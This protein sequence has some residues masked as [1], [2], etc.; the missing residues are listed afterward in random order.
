M[1]ETRLTE[2]GQ[3]YMKATAAEWGWD[4]YWGKP[5][6]SPTGGIWG[7]PQG[8]VGLLFKKGWNVRKVEPDEDDPITCRLWHSGRWLHTSAGIGAGQCVLNVC[9]AYGV[10]GNESLN[11]E[12]WELVICYLSRLGNA[13]CILLTDANFNFD[14]LHKIPSA[15][16]TA[17][18]DGWLV[19]ADRAHA[20]LHG[21]PCVC[22]F[23]KDGKSA[24]R[25]DGLLVTPAQ[26]GT[27]ADVSALHDHSLPGH[28]PVCFTFSL[29]APLQKVIKMRKLP[30]FLPPPRSEEDAQK[31]SETLLRPHQDEWEQLLLGGDVNAIWAQWTWLAEEVGMAL[32]CTHLTIDTPAPELP[33]APKATPRGRGT[34]R[35]LQETTLAPRSIA[36]TGGPRTR[37]LSKITGTLGALR[38]VI[39]WQRSQAGIK[40]K[41]V[42]ASARRKA[43]Q[44]FRPGAIP[45]QVELSW[46]AACR[47]MRKVGSAFRE[48]LLL[49]EF[50]ALAPDP[51]LP[52]DRPLPAL[53]DT[54]HTYDQLCLLGK[55]Y[56]RHEERARLEKWKAKMDSAW[57]DKPKEVYKWIQNEYQPP[58]VMLLDPD[59][60]QP[61]SNIQRMDEILHASWDKV[62]RKYADTPEPDVRAFA[63]KY[64]RFLEKGAR[65]QANPITGARL[66]KCLRKMGVHTAT[67]LDGW[68][69]A[70]LLPLP[71]R[72]LDMLS[73][74]LHLI[75]QTGCWPI[76]LAR[77]YVSLIPK[78][79][80]MLPMQQRPLSVLSQIYRVWAGIRL[81]KCM[82]WQEHWI[83]P[84]AY[85]FRKKRGATDA[86]SHI[87][88]LLELHKLIKKVLH[89]FGLDYVK[90]FDLIP[91]SIVLYIAL[92][93]GM[94]P[95][96][97]KALSGMYHTLTRCF[98]IMGCCASF[99]AATNG[100][101][102]GCPLS[103]ILINLMT[104]VWKRVLDAQQQGITVSVQRLPPSDQPVQVMH[105]VLTAL[106][107]ADDTYGFAAGSNTLTPLL[108]C[109][110]TWL[111]DT[112]QGVNAKKS[113]GFSSDKQHPV[114]AALQGVPFPISTEFKSLGAGVRTT[115][116]TCSG[117]LILKRIARACS[118]L[119]RVHGAQGN[120]ERRCDVISTMITATG[121]HAAEIVPL[122]PR[123]LLPFESKVMRTI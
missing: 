112:G 2:A 49:H 24:N 116:A 66:A 71:V 59:T 118:L 33:F 43:R 100:I 80:G 1:E 44:I 98:K 58:L 32:S 104:S 3:R 17:M 65:M 4:C 57:M 88:M 64:D 107:Y 7:A 78:G 10:A 41:K 90:C 113:V 25:I 34:E 38:T 94:D 11:R 122:R 15:P 5:L 20:I 21:K 75:E 52:S 35:M 82:Q 60:N 22:G 81:E 73:Q 121:L 46:K 39:Q 92:A 63:L 8:G 37:L 26:A 70:D 89:G 54:M 83:H 74:L 19:D 120:F 47:R 23:S 115:D 91:Q 123:D 79:E 119:G 103:V 40:G 87:S 31:I 72:P 18:A 27:L 55:K 61:T 12:F 16:L 53:V 69:V 36:P 84:H 67:G 111:Q 50:V 108:D 45:K 97:H 13:G 29:D 77:G 56:A 28:V 14:L 42:P 102:Q 93:Q 30:P 101:L 95:G 106:G 62:M 9:V 114:Q 110:S 68:C 86:A 51:T 6:S 99:F 117:P 105:Y 48:D 76:I 96:T 109:T 85:G